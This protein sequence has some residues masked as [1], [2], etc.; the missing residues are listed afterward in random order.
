MIGLGKANVLSHPPTPRAQTPNTIT[1]TNTI[2]ASAASVSRWVVGG[3]TPGASDDQL[4]T[5]MKM[6]RVPMK[7]R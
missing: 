4:A 5:K 3:S 6:N 1:A 2:S 7:G